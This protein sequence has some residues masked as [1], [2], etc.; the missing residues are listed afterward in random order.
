[1]IWYPVG[2]A[3]RQMRQKISGRPARNLHRKSTQGSRR[4]KKAG[5]YGCPVDI[6]KAASLL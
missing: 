3:R 2:T 1:M 6:Q 5:K 4:M